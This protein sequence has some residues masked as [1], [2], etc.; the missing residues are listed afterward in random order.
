MIK[1][2]VEISS[3]GRLSMKNR[4]LVVEREKEEAVCVPIED[5]GILI[6]D[7]PAIVAT[8]GLITACAEEGV[9]VIFCDSKH[10][11]AGVLMPVKG[12]ELQTKTIAGQVRSGMPVRKR[13]WQ[14]IISAKIRGQ[15]GVLERAGTEAGA[16]RAFAQMVR[17][18]DPDNLEAQA[19]RLYWPRLFGDDFRRERDAP[20]INALLNYGYAIMRS[21]TAR[22]VVATGLHPSIGL[23]HRN[24]YNAFCLADDLLEPVRPLVDHRVYEIWK[25]NADRLEITR[26]IKKNLLDLLSADCLIGGR[27]LPLMSGLHYYAASVRK[28]ITKEEKDVEIPE[29]W[30]DLP[31][32]QEGATPPFE[33][34]AKDMTLAHTGD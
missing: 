7:H 16:L 2:V 25:S 23:H 24:Q 34:G 9:A 1:R 6:L 12:N 28:V 18:G 19:A 30:C 29:I 31:P 22:A 11:P 5:I 32:L 13:L 21:A 27:R 8:H 20:G 10:H 33:K 4:Q 14:S 3:P 17:S 26:E 15:A